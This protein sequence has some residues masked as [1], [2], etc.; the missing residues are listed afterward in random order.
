MPDSSLISPQATGF[1][2]GDTKLSVQTGDFKN[3]LICSA[4]RTVSRTTYAALFAV[5]GTTYGAG[6][7]STTFNLPKAAGRAI[8]AAGSGS[9][10]TS[11][12]VASATGTETHSNSLAETAPHNH[13]LKGTGSAGTPGT[14]AYLSNVLG[15]GTWTGTTVTTI[16]GIQ[17]VG[18][19]E[20][21]QNMQP[22]LFLGN[23]FILGL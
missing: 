18:S 7:G 16:S 19:G 4:E 17:S 1:D 20:A 5:I 6:D 9:G 12:S 15:K 21:H 23:L 14:H 11:R 8:G 2:I 13:D 22:T 3:W 10:L